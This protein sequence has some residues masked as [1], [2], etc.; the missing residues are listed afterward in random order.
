MLRGKES[1]EREFDSDGGRGLLHVG[2]PLKQNINK[3]REQVM[4]IAGDRAFHQHVQ[5]PWGRA[6]LVC[7]VNSRRNRCLERIGTED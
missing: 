6:W 3:I 1:Q 5:R 2:W 4:Q 7:L